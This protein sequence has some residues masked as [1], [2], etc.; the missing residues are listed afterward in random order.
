MRTEPV[1]IYSDLSNSAV[2]RHPQ[3]SFPGVLIQGDTLHR[4]CLMAD[5][6]CEGANSL[7]GTDAWD[8]L[9]AL[10]E[11][12]RDKLTHYKAVLGEHGLPLP[13]SENTR[14]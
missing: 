11:S 8:E 1:D 4:L 2:M 13:F 10:R 9:I 7:R 5:A 14:P 6:A 3:R 12:L